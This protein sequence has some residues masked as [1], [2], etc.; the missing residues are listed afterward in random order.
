MA[1]NV[2]KDAGRGIGMNL[3]AERVREVGGRVSVATQLNRFTRIS[4]SLPATNKRVN[5]TEAA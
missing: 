3:I 5:V 1:N 4:V 2:T